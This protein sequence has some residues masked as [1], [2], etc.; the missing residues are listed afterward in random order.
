MD[1]GLQSSKINISSGNNDGLKYHHQNS[2]S[3]HRE[4]QFFQVTIIN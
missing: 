4:H 1:H 2:D 3:F